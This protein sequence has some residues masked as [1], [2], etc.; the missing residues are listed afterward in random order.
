[1][2]SSMPRQPEPELM[3][4]KDEAV[5]YAKADFAAVNEAFVQRLLALAGPLTTGRLLDLGTGPGDIP[6]RV[7]RARPRWH[8][9]AVD[10]SQ[11]MIQLARRAADRAGVS[12]SVELVLGDAK[13]TSL[14][15]AGFDVVFSNSILHHVNETDRLWAEV[16]RLARPG[17]M[18]LFR[19]LARPDNEDV[20]RRIV[21]Q[22]SGQESALLKDEFYRSL[23]AAYTPEE[24]REQLDRAGLTTLEVAM[25]SDRHLDVF[26]RTP[27]AGPQR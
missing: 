17:G 20:A 3:D 18:V 4:L 27:Q 12:A 21:E 11:A 2:T 22:Y 23:L 13:T 7:A 10:A 24:V 19:D 5:A 8:I 25:V 6:I 9:V 15:T 16:K 1:M 26:G 14:P